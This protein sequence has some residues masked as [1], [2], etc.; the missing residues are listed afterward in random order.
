MK[1]IFK[2]SMLTSICA[3]I[4]IISACSSAPVNQA[5]T[6]ANTPSEP[7]IITIKAQAP[8]ESTR[9]DA[10]VA[11]ADQLNAELKAEGRPEQVKVDA[12]IFTGSWDEYRKQFILAFK[13]KKEPDIYVNGHDE[14]SWL[15]KGN[16]ILPLNELKDST[17]FQDM[18]PNLWN[19][20]TWKGNIWGIP[21]DTEARPIFYRKDLLKKMGWSDEE[22]K[23]LPE[24]VKNGEFTL[25]DMT[26]VGKEAQAAGIAKIGVLHR[27]TSGPDFHMMAMNFGATLY[28]PNKDQLIFDKPAILKTLTYLN[29]LAQ[30]EKVM[31]A[32]ITSM[33]FKNVWTM[34]KEGNVLFYYGGIWNVNSLMQN[35]MTK[36]EV[37]DKFGFTLI[38]AAEKGGQPITLS[39]PQVYTISSQTKHKDLAVRLLELASAPDYQAKHSILTWHFPVTKSGADAKE[40]KDDPFLSRTNY[41]LDY[42]TYL[43]NNENFIK[44]Q[45]IFYKA[46]Q[47]VELGK[48]SPE[49]AVKNMDS[50]LKTSFGGDLIIKEN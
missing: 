35:G 12:S 14:L 24:K 7:Q 17:A 18:Y 4:A 22:I 49:D 3:C 50:E 27:P 29:D 46:I 28:D 36:E 33:E 37:L 2:K 30:V 31:P 45:D 32:S 1:N 40:F 42:T 44:Y 41:M 21:Q 16:Y 25:D 13:S 43:P 47:A 39:H 20:V 9:L 8:V 26:R 5:A 15:A 48:L 6:N 38:P 34:L 23:S 19:S 11:A 10:I